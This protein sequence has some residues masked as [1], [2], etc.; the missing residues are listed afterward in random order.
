MMVEIQG[1]RDVVSALVPVVGK[2]EEGKV[3]ESNRGEE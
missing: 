3:A 1:G 2:A